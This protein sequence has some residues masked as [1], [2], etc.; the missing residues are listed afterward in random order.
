MGVL[1]PASRRTSHGALSHFIGSQASPAN[2]KKQVRQR[3]ARNGT[4]EE[5][6]GGRSEQEENLGLTD[7][8]DVSRG[9]KN[10]PSLR[11]VATVSFRRTL[12]PRSDLGMIRN[13]GRS[14]NNWCPGVHTGHQWLSGPVDLDGD[15]AGPLEPTTRDHRGREVAPNRAQGSGR[16]VWPAQQFV[17]GSRKLAD[18]ACGP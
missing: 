2:A 10:Y 3:T 14:T 13:Q 8:E 7:P 6:S 11:P 4:A 17:R 5:K 15:V 16:I 12:T 18:A 9:L 1:S